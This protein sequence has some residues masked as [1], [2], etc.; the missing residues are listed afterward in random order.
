M[1]IVIIGGTGHIGTFLVPRLVALGHEVIVVS[2]QRRAPY[3]SHDGWA[4]ANIISMDRDALEKENQFGKAIAAIG[5]DVVVDLICF[6][7][8]KCRQLTDALQGKIE[9]FLHCGTVWIH[10]YN[11]LVPVKE[12]DDKHPMEEYGKQK[13]AIEKF[14]LDCDQA[15]LP[16][17]VLHPGH[18]VGPGWNPVNP[19]GNC[20]NI[21]SASRADI[22]VAARAT[23]RTT[24]RKFRG[25]KAN[26]AAATNGHPNM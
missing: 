15:Q 14:L 6:E 8:E 1:K 13:A 24:T 10:G 22:K 23:P 19:I 25:T 20:K 21:F 12:T 17:T 16:S 2:R 18:I 9:H 4:K 11:A 5:A 3:Q 26:T 7:L